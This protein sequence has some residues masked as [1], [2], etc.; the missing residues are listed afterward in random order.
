[1]KSCMVGLG[2]ST[3]MFLVT[4]S[5][6][7]RD[8]RQCKKPECEPSSTVAAASTSQVKCLSET[9]CAIRRG[10]VKKMGPEKG[11]ENKNRIRYK[12]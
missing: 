6:C 5:I 4:S 7:N 12:L 9:K 1:M 2:S 11:K 3:T 10:A 8:A